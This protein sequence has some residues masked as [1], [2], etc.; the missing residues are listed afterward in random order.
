MATGRGLGH[1]LPCKARF[2]GWEK[3]EGRK[4]EG[5]AL[6]GGNRDAEMTGGGLL[7]S[8]CEIGAGA[9]K[10]A[11][12]SKRISVITRLKNA[13][14]F[15][16]PSLPERTSRSASKGC[17][18]S[19]S[20]TCGFLAVGGGSVTKVAGALS[21]NRAPSNPG[22]FLAV[23]FGEKPGTFRPSPTIVGKAKV[24]TLRE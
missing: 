4:L 24:T 15:L 8:Y 7:K 19:K 20:K 9:S 22:E 14:K 23:I 13:V 3:F 5:F 21:S 18:N 12:G 10:I 2:G 1:S 11:D 16:A 6:A 17:A